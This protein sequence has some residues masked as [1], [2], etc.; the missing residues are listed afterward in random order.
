M[1]ISHTQFTNN[2]LKDQNQPQTKKTMKDL[3]SCFSTHAVRVAPNTRS[4]N[5]CTVTSVYLSRLTSHKEILIRLTWSKNH[6][7]LILTVNLDDLSCSTSQTKTRS[8]AM[9]I[10]LSHKNKGNRTYVSQSCTVELYWDVSHAK[11]DK[12]L[13]EPISGFHVVMY[14]ESELVLLMGDMNHKGLIN[15]SDQHI[16]SPVADTSLVSQKEQVHGCTSYTTKARFHSSEKEHKISINCDE[17][18][19]EFSVRLDDYCVVQTKNLKW[20]FRGNEMIYVDYSP[21]DM[22]WDLHGWLSGDNGAQGNGCATFMFMSR[23]NRKKWLWQLEED[24]SVR[25]NFCFTIQMSRGGH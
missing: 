4:S 25:S 19:H 7:G 2:N 20:N 17:E 14:V 24:D 13:P 18:K 10:H 21:V 1:N 23:T 3:T 11:Y 15:K 9:P 22:M 16:N 5:A 8:T 6:N 12:V